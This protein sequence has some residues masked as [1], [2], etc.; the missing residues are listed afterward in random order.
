MPD[1]KRRKDLLRDGRSI[2]LFWGIPIVAMVV[3][4]ALPH[5]AKTVIWIIALIWMGAACLINARRCGRTHCYYTGPFFLLMTIPVALHGFEV[6]WLGPEGWKWLGLA[7]GVLGG[8]LWC[9]TEKFMGSY[10]TWA[11]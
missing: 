6:V 1:Q 2:V 8:A 5:P 9:T 11:R 10:R 4:I 7:I 3:S